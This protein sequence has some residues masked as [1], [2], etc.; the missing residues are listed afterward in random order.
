MNVT[1]EKFDSMSMYVF[2]FLGIPFLRA[3]DLV[4][5]LEFRDLVSHLE[6]CWTKRLGHLSV[7]KY[8]F[9]AVGLLSEC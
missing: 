7:V 2:Y 3:N 8:V 4:S 5:S 1:V 6:I 9:L